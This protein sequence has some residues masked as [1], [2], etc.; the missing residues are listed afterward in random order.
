MEN[1]D[2]VQRAYDELV[3]SGEIYATSDQLIVEGHKAYLTRR[4]AYYLNLNNPDFGLL[5]KTTGNNVMGLSVDIVMKHNGDFYDIATDSAG[6]VRPVNSG[7]V[8]DPSLANRWVQPTKELAGFINVSPVPIPIPIPT[9]VP[10]PVPSND[11]Q[12]ILDI[13][14]I[15]Q[16]N[17]AELVNTI[18]NLLHLNQ[19]EIINKL[20]ALNANQSVIFPDYKSSGWLSIT[21]SPVK[22]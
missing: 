10:I 8:S 5:S 15:I 22:K 9:P 7:V 1:F 13:L 3:K 6:L 18:F 17:Q 4:A 16:S 21:L 19:A 12:K 14:T 20:D 11:Y 2:L